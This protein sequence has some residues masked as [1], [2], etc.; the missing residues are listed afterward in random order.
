MGK[1]SLGFSPMIEGSAR[2][3]A[4]TI[5]TMVRSPSWPPAIRSWSTAKVISFVML[6]GGLISSA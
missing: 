5:V 4:G 3:S 2:V 6:A 1:T